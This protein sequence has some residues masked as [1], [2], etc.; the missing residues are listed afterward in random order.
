MEEQQVPEVEKEGTRPKV[1]KSFA[2]LP[3]ANSK[4][5]SATSAGPSVM[6]R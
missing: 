4:A 3:C 5:A 6:A 1:M 2:T